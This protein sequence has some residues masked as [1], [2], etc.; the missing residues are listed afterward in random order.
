MMI[1]AASFDGTV[2]IWKA[3]NK[4]L[5]QWELIASLEG[6]ENEV[7]SVCWSHDG[8]WL[9]SCGRDKAVWIWENLGQEEFECVCNESCD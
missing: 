2:G 6:H 3:K 4:S 8:K 7:K 5:T 9:A 1:A